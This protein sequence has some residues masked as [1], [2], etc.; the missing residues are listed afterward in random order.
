MR[1]TA[2]ERE[3][4][5][6]LAGAQDSAET[7]DRLF[8]L[9]HALLADHRLRRFHLDSLLGDGSPENPHGELYLADAEGRIIAG[10]VFY[11]PENTSGCPYYDRPDVASLGPLAIVPEFQGHGLG[12]AMLRFVEERAVE[13]GAKEL[14]LEITPEATNALNKFLKEGYRF[15]E[16]A[17]YNDGQQRCIVMTKSLT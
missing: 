6:R 4:E 3:V 16:N 7:V 10:V 5:I 8:H 1:Y 2:L 17:R 9:S 15:A 13:V 12:G 11:D 14:A